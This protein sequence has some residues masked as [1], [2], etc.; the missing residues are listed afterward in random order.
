[1]IK[2]F[3][4]VFGGLG[5]FQS[6][7]L[8][9]KEAL[10]HESFIEVVQCTSN[11]INQAIIDADVV[12]PFMEKITAQTLHLAPKLKMI[13][14]FGVGLEGVDIDEATRKGVWV[15][16]ISSGDCCNDKSSAEH[17]I[18]LALA[19]CRDQKAMH[20]S[21]MT[22]KLG[23][24]TGRSLF[25]AKAVI[26]GF[27]GIGRQLAKRLSAFDMQV[28]AVTRT[29]P[30]PSDALQFQETLTELCDTAGFPRLAASA[31]IV[32]IC[33]SQNQSNI[34]LVD[35][36]FLDHLKDSAII[37]N[38]AR[39]RVIC[40]VHAKNLQ[41]CSSCHPIACLH[42]WKL[43]ART[44]QCQGGLINYPDVLEALGTGKLF[45]VGIDVYH[46]EP[47]PSP[48]GDPFLSHP[49]VVATPHVAGVTHISYQNMA[50][51]VAAEIQRIIAN[52]DPLRAVNIV[53][54]TT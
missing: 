23:C 54:G 32:F 5:H 27:G 26:Y 51:I 33:C 3:K 6:A 48:D 8:L 52:Q 38:V 50:D 21:L 1:M 36:V 15:C 4:V 25:G 2:K 39:V 10:R 40:F 18:Y 14:Q 47:F 34:G 29:M 22:H 9:T 20:E 7:F 46:T 43:L 28:A 30:S 16:N 42:I 31:D 19:V 11:S 41:L 44:T 37:V 13:M 35:K 53:E 45:G 24:P 49:R 12:V 17:A